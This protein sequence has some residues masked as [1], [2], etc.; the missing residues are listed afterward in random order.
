M[1]MKTNV[2]IYKTYFRNP[3][4]VIEMKIFIKKV[5]SAIGRDGLEDGVCVFEKVIDHRITLE[6]IEEEDDDEVVSPISNKKTTFKSKFSNVL[7]SIRRKIRNSSDSDTKAISYRQNKICC[8]KVKLN[9]K[10][11]KAVNSCFPTKSSQYSLH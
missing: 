7:R 9:R 5:K 6:D 1:H 4:E 8:S 3:D 10:W 2:T 11:L